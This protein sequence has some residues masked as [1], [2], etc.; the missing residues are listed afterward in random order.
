MEGIFSSLSKQLA[1]KRECDRYNQV[2]RKL[3]GFVKTEEDSIH[4]L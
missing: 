1:R 4:N 3:G 2:G